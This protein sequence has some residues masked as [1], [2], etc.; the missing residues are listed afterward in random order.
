MLF[1]ITANLSRPRMSS[2]PSSGFLPLIPLRKKLIYSYVII[3]LIEGVVAFLQTR[4]I[5]I[6]VNARSESTVEDYVEEIGAE[7]FGQQPVG[8]GVMKLDSWTSGDRMTLVANEDYWGEPLAFDTFVVRFIDDAATRLIELE[9]GAVDAAM[10]LDS[11]AI[12]SLANG[13]IEGGVVATIPGWNVRYFGLSTDPKWELLQDENV[14]AAIFHAIDVEAICRSVIG[15]AGIYTTSILPDNI[16]VGYSDH[17]AYG[18][19][20]DL[21]R[22]L[23]AKA[24]YADGLV[25]NVNV[26]QGTLDVKIAEAIQ[27][28]LSEVGITLNVNPMEEFATVGAAIRGEIE[29]A[30]FNSP[31]TAN[32][33]DQVVKTMKAGSGHGVAEIKIT[34]IA[35]LLDEAAITM[36]LAERQSLYEQVQDGIYENYIL[37]PINQYV[38]GYAYLDYVQGFEPSP[39]GT[40]FL[41]GV[42]VAG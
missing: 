4:G 39:T 24:G 7:A 28:Y 19:D 26:A 41:R 29:T 15:S 12:D 22:S 8:S 32:E 40:F 21:S 31:A 17:E 30:F 5:E 34:A 3:A 35:D 38:Y 20:P 37:L 42:T 25:I 1:S 10:G 14:R 18:Y 27:A 2:I 6:T 16:A 33:P 13:E 36:D 11:N 23:L 9:T